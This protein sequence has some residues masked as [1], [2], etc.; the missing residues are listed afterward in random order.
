[1]ANHK[2]GLLPRGSEQQAR[3]AEV[4]IRHDDIV[5]FDDVDDLIGKRALLCVPVLAGDHV[6]HEH[7]RWVQEDDRVSRQRTS[8]TSMKNLKPALGGRKMITVQNSNTVVWDQIRQPASHRSDNRCETICGMFDQRAR[9]WV[10]TPLS[11]SYNAVRDTGKV[12]NT[13]WNAALTVG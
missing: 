5:G 10:S 3:R 6:G 7:R 9:D 4:S 11:L 12:P 1:M 8:D 2:E 13:A